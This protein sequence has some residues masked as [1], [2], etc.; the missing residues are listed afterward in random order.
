[1]TAF[2]Q[3]RLCD[4]GVNEKPKLSNKGNSVI[5]PWVLAPKT[6]LGIGKYLFLPVCKAFVYAVSAKYESNKSCG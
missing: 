2:S 4:H 5:L 3:K 1:M 6:F